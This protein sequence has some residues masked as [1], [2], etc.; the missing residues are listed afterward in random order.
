[1]INDPSWPAGGRFSVEVVP[2]R[3]TVRVV[4][5]GELDLLTAKELDERLYD[6]RGAGFARIVLDLRRLAFLDSTGVRLI[7]VHDGLARE[8]GCAFALIGGPP[9]V[10]RV[11]EVCGLLDRLTFLEP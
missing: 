11:F 10:Q 2:E 1:M 4:P 7:V 6:L 3:D 9:P 5:A 8:N